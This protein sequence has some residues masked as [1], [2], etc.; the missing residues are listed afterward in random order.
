[1]ATSAQIQR[2]RKAFLRAAKRSERKT[3]T[4]LEKLEREMERLL[5]RK[6]LLDVDDANRLNSLYSVF[7]QTIKGM[8]TS[9]TDF[10]NAVAW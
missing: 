6:R 10:L 8:E 4:S 3:D 2:E 9:L 5:K 1:M 7:V